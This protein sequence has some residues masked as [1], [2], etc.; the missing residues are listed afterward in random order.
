MVS[1]EGRSSRGHAS[2][3]R[4]RLWSGRRG[5]AAGVRP[6]ETRWRLQRSGPTLTPTLLQGK[7]AEVVLGRL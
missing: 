5:P 7:V 4:C 3:G 1:E 2:D 6:M